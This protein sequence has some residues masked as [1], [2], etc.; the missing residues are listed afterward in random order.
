MRRQYQHLQYHWANFNET[1]HKASLSLCLSLSLSL[2]LTLAIC[3][4]LSMFVS[5]SLSL[6]VYLSLSLSLFLSVCLCLSPSLRCAC[7]HHLWRNN[8]PSL[9][10]SL[11]LHVER[12]KDFKENILTNVIID[13]NKTT[14]AVKLTIVYFITALG[15]SKARYWT[16]PVGKD[17]RTRRTPHQALL[18]ALI[19]GN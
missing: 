7:A 13:E 9:S 14:R 15:V 2:C 1:C 10:L 5:L 4:C 18:L 19:L 8:T 6:Y 11:S 17:D 3:L 12:W 16:E